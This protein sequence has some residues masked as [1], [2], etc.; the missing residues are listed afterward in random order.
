MEKIS[1]RGNIYDEG[2]YINDQKTG[3]WKMYD[4]KGNLSKK[5]QYLAKDGK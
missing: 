1:S 3:E 2:K 5:K 4:V